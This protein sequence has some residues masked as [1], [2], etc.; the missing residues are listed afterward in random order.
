MISK[1]LIKI[2]N[3]KF[4]FE[5]IQEFILAL[6]LYENFLTV[7]VA[8]MY[9]SKNDE[10][11]MNLRNGYKVILKSY[12]LHWKRGGLR[13]LSDVFVRK[14]YSKHGLTIETNDTVIILGAHVGVFTIYSASKLSSTGRII[15]VEPAP[16]NYK[17]LRK[18]IK[19]NKLKNVY[20]HQVAIS[21]TG[22]PAKLYINESYYEHSLK[23]Q[24]D[25]YIEVK[26]LT[27]NKLFD[28]H[29]I[30]ICHLLKLDIE[31][32]EWGVFDS[33]STIN[34]GKIQQ[35]AME[36]HNS[37]KGEIQRLEKKLVKS[38]FRVSLLP[39]S[40]NKTTGYLYAKRER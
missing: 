22:K 29:R 38:G 20:T 4:L 8:F 35:I 2:F 27:L 40:K 33:L 14:N 6:F 13:E 24:T 15:A 26:T 3:K 11:Q 34:L 28:L 1:I 10:V 18:N 25:E 39:N 9:K 19:L 32:A 21:S 23:N 12:L 17:L 37:T 16:E 7:L 5:K 36:Y 30:R 31:G